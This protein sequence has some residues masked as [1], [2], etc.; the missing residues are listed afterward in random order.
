MT[1]SYFG[2]P[3]NDQLAA[4]ID[5]EFAHQ[6]SV[7]YDRDIAFAV[8]IN[9]AGAL[10]GVHESSSLPPVF[11]HIYGERAKSENPEG[12]L[13]NI[14]GKLRFVYRTGLPSSEARNRPD[15]LEPG[16]FP[17][18]GAGTYRGYTGGVSAFKEETDWWVFCRIVDKLIELR[19]SAANSAIVASKSKDRKPGQKYLQ[20]LGVAADGA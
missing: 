6:L 12:Y 7:K 5:D 10:C 14:D 19:S 1:G 18:E 9:T 16:D 2:V 17:A 13:D 20:N 15:L 3:V 4:W 11:Q 8:K